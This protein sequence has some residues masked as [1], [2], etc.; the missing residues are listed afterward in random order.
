MSLPNLIPGDATLIEN[1]VN[2]L[3]AKGIFDEFRHECLADVD[4]K[5]TFVLF[6]YCRYFNHS[7]ICL[8]FCQMFV[9]LPS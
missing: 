4:T 6:F 1:I 2:Y 9:C 8:T 3:K 7:L 5:V